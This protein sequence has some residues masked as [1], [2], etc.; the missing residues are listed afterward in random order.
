MPNLAHRVSAVYHVSSFLAGE[1]VSYIP[2]ERQLIKVALM[3]PCV[4]SNLNRVW[5]S[6]VHA[7]DGGKQTKS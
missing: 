7:L 5:V 1:L 6:Y 3:H 2:E 4:S